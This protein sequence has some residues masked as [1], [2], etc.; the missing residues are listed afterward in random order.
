[1]KND[2]ILAIIAGGR[3]GYEDFGG[4]ENQQHHWDLALLHHLL[5][6]QIELALIAGIDIHV[7]QMN[8][9]ACLASAAFCCSGSFDRLLHSS[10]ANETAMKMLIS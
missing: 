1:M 7:R 3:V 8:L 5:P 2:A 4:F 10:D 9:P 6:L